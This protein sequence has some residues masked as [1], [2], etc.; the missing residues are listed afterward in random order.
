MNSLLSL[1]GLKRALKR[2]ALLIS[3]VFICGT[4]LSLLFALQRPDVYEATA[5]IQIETPKITSNLASGGTVTTTS[6]NRLKLIEQ[7]LMSRD[8]ILAMIEKFDLYNGGDAPSDSI[9]VGLLRDSIQITELIDPAQAWRPNVQPSGLSITVRLNDARKAADI[10]NELLAQVLAE[11]KQRSEIRASQTLAF[12]EAE[13]A[14]LSAEI[15]ALALEFA[16]FKE[17][18]A[19]SLPTNIEAQ[20]DQLARLQESQLE[21]E[22][23]VI[24]IETNSTR[25]RAEERKHQSEFLT[26]QLSLLETR[27]AEVEKALAAAPEIERLY[28]VMERGL[29]QLQEQ[30]SAITTRRTEAAMAQQL[31][32]QNQFERFEV[33]ETALVP[34]YPVS[35]GKKKLVLAGTIASLLAGLGLGFAFEW[36]SPVMRTSERVEQELGLRPVVILP[37]LRKP[38]N[39]W[40]EKLGLRA[41]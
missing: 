22:T 38:R 39:G 5:V 36:F 2:R 35:S 41:A 30:Y 20:Y 34:E 4:L 17:R 32:S 21:I 31:E 6:G 40:R 28:G 24:E 9:R 19:A 14:R 27:I 3:V 25:L 11:G 7:K 8:S 29:T 33:L 1:S 16:R 23:R 15:E 37:V 10:A 12:L 13:E 18:N 26:Q